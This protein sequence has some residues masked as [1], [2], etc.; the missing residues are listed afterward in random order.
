M[1]ENDDLMLEYFHDSILIIEQ[2]LKAEMRE[3]DI[4]IL[5]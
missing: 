5:H 4:L 3:A 2:E 1:K